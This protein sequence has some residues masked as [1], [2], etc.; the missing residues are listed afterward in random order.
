MNAFDGAAGNHASRNAVNGI[1]QLEKHLGMNTFA[2]GRFTVKIGSLAIAVLALSSCTQWSFAQGTTTVTKASSTEVQEAYKGGA[3]NFDEFAQAVQEVQK[4]RKER[5]VTAK[6]FA[7]L[8]K[9][10]GTLVLDAR[11][12]ISYGLL[13]VKNSVNLPYTNFGME[14]LGK[15][16]PDETTTILIYCR[17]NIENDALKRIENMALSEYLV[18][19]ARPAGLNLPVAVTL[20]I[21]GYRN[22][23]E[24]DEIVDPDHCPIPFEWTPKSTEIANTIGVKINAP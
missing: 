16:I 11:S 18:A 15:L 23:Y 6:K 19:K 2:S 24:L 12:E 14:T 8:A 9:K 1:F 4:H 20:Y 13:H 5:L 3:C 21:Y 10:P 17:N 7:E 22:V